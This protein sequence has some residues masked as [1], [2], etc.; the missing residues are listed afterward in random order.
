[1][2]E[3]IGV[4]EA[5]PVHLDL[6]DAMRPARQRRASRGSARARRRRGRSP[7]TPALA[8]RPS[9]GGSCSASVTVELGIAGGDRTSSA[10]LRIAPELAR[11]LLDRGADPPDAEV[12]EQ[13]LARARQRGRDQERGLR[14]RRGPGRASAQLDG[15][16]GARPR[17]AWSRR[18][19]TAPARD[20]RRAA[21]TRGPCRRAATRTAS[22][23]RSAHDGAH[24]RC[25]VRTTRHARCMK[26]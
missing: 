14:Q 2:R 13:H 1:M 24:A 23:R 19:R 7:G 9:A 25:R 3:R 17:R 18:T 26:R 8:S 20:P 16:P 11:D 6:G 15:L 4:L 22:S 10:R 12:L 21:R 5:V